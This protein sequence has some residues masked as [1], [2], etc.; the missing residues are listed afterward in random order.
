[1]LVKHDS[2]HHFLF[3]TSFQ[4]NSSLGTYTL[5]YYHPCIENN[6]DTN[7]EIIIIYE[8]KLAY[9]WCK[10]VYN[11]LKMLKIG[12]NLYQR[13]EPIFFLNTGPDAILTYRVF[14]LIHIVLF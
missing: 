10:V 6:T 13:S 5:Q 1:M 14:I 11:Y 3:L 4:E 12:S 7:I 8:N 9:L 2:Q